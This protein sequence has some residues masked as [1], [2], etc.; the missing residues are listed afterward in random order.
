MS[1]LGECLRCVNEGLG[2]WIPQEVYLGI[3]A[4]IKTARSKVASTQKFIK[5]KVH[6]L[7]L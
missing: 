2:P 3:Y 4:Q 6:S 5:A 1:G 7:T